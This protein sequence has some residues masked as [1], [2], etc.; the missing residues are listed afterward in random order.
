MN[1]ERWQRV[2]GIL[3]SAMELHPGERAAYLDRECAGD[4]ALRKD[5]DEFLSIE[6]KV[7]P[8]FL[9][10][11]AAEQVRRTSTTAVADT[12]LAVGTKLG[13]YEVQALLGAGGMG[14]VYRA[15]DS[16]L[17]RIV[18]IKIIPHS[19]SQDPARLQ[20]F[21][22]EARAI[23]VLQHPN[24]CTLY[25]VG[26]QD[27]TQFLV[28]EYL[29]GETLAKRLQK[30]R[31]PIELTL[32]HG[33]EIAD[34][35]DAAHHRGIVH[36]DLKPANI[37]LTSHGEAKV[38][39]FGLAKLDEPL[40][41]EAGLAEAITR[42]KLLTTPGV[43]MGTASYM[44]PEQARG[45]DL[46]ARTDIFSLGAVL[47]EM[48][49]GKV[50]FPGKTP[51]IVHK[52]IL[53][54]TPPPP[55]EIVPSLPIHFD[56][57]VAKTLEKDPGLRYQSAT[58]L[59]A[60]LNRLKRE[61]SSGRIPVSGAGTSA[62]RHLNR[63][64]WLKVSIVAVLIAVSAAS[65]LY[66]RSRQQ[67]KRLTDKDTI[68][69]AD[70]ANSTGDPVFD[71]TT[72]REGLSAQLEQSPFLNLLSDQQVMAILPLMEQPKDAKLTRELARK[73]CQRTAGAIT[74][75]GS[76]ASLG[77][78]YVLGLRGVNC[79]TGDMLADLQ[80]TT[81]AKE[82]VLTALG[83]LATK[84]RTKLGES[85]ASVQKYDV[86]P[87]NVTTSS[88]EALQEFSLG[89]QAADKEDDD[90]AIPC[91]LQAVTLD[92]NFAMAYLDL[93]LRYSG[94]GESRLGEE[95]IQKAYDL[96]ERVSDREKFVISG[97]YELNLEGDLQA[98]RNTFEAYSK[99]FPRSTSALGNLHLVYIS[100][101]DYNK[102]LA[103]AQEQIKIDPRSSHSYYQLILDY[104]S[105]NRLD[106]GK[107]AAEK[108]KTQGLESD[109][110][111]GFFFTIDFLQHD[112]AGMDHEIKRMQPEDRMD[113]E[114]LVAWSEGRL[115]KARELAGRVAEAYRRA[116]YK[117]GADE[118]THDAAMQNA[119]IGK[120]GLARQ[121][122]RAALIHRPAGRGDLAYL[123]T[124]LGLSGD[125]EEALRQAADLAKRF[126]K[127]TIIKSEYVPII[128]AS[129]ALNT[130][131]ASRAIEVLAPTVSYEMGENRLTLYSTYLRG[132][133]YLT[134]HQGSAAAAE[135]QRIL[136]HPGA[137]HWHMINM[138]G[139][140]AHLQIGRAFAMQGDTAKAK[141]A[142]QE[143]LM[144]WKDADPD[145]PILNQ[146]KAEYAKL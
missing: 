8:G 130:G 146:A 92:P 51:A 113:A 128:K 129:A 88:L 55:S 52:A 12:I 120:I 78:A 20:R 3:E 140:L 19:L 142:Y 11:P 90:D 139:V 76:I 37:L 126:P 65:G 116:G 94:M 81:N 141:T 34:A 85:L 74:V 9:E 117:E 29:E 45:E 60:D 136:D 98:A 66:Y 123:A 61:S 103:L 96:R 57:L 50:A 127:D 23:A 137:A 26:A 102:A 101:G 144:L 49:T 25:D 43:A 99:T 42:E 119:L 114:S 62:G 118:Y 125:T 106:E 64:T 40:P 68:I 70:F 89:I 6:G 4:P 7:E 79:R 105:L 122:I 41:E 73:V 13:P 24:I 115:G 35:L 121:Q 5:V 93:G 134:A 2:R 135:F 83:E 59:R 58:D 38:L 80:A 47:Y 16:R 17:N 86:P 132:L 56:E 143:F 69:V 67:I 100:I 72:L 75:E 39:D 63:R 112:A 36:R 77:T 10:M 110:I 33:A 133:A 109:P 22:R 15:R 54:S 108:A 53:D 124:A 18:A 87:Q 84:L 97:V 21:E 95:S 31:L 71:G 111:L 48:A 138:I 44:S 82:Q 30:G 91:L 131:S 14:E 104:L 1:P 27:G 46:D 28:M 145:I 32:R 107:A